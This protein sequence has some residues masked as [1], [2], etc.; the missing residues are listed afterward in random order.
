M[1]PLCGRCP[2]PVVCV[3]RAR[4]RPEPLSPTAYGCSAISSAK[5]LSHVLPSFHLD[6]H[7]FLSV[8]SPEHSEGGQGQV[9][10]KICR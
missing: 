1:A 8:E 6:P 10:P 2:W 4:E 3:A 5:T 7:S 9:K